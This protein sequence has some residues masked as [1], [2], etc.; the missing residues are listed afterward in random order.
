MNKKELEYI[1]ENYFAKDPSIRL[2]ME[3]VDKAL[4][5]KVNLDQRTVT[6]DEDV[7]IALPVVRISEAWGRQGNSDRAIIESFTRGIGGE[8][9][10]QKLQSI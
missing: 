10:E 7:N 5:E 1:T 9:L 2:I 3:M 6:P 8:S 4:Q